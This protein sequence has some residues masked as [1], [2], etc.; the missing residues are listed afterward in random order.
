VLTILLCPTRTYSRQPIAQRS[1]YITFTRSVTMCCTRIVDFHLR[2]TP[3]RPN[4]TTSA[5]AL[6]T[7]WQ[8]QC[9]L[10]RQKPCRHYTY[11]M[12]NHFLT[13]CDCACTTFALWVR[14]I[15]HRFK[16][17]L[18]Q[19]S[20]IVTLL[21]PCV[22]HG[23]SNTGAHRER[24]KRYESVVIGVSGV[25]VTVIGALITAIGVFEWKCWTARQGATTVN[26]PVSAI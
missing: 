18:I 15:P 11:P 7:T 21:L 4:P 20:V 1:F 6:H 19:P 2:S 16:Y 17:R 24:Q 26:R 22:V 25:V 13:Q 9:L 12:E 3:P 14:H 5:A 8:S 10:N 23:S